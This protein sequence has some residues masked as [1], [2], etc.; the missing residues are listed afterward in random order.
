MR[1]R[2][3]FLTLLLALTAIVAFGRPDG[4]AS[5][6]LQDA[7]TP[8]AVATPTATVEV[9]TL[10][11]WYTPD[12]SGEFLAIGPIRVNDVLVA[13]PG[14]PNDRTM[15]GQVDFDDENN[16]DLPR[17]E[18]GETIFNAYL[19][20]PDDPDAL[21]SWIYPQD[22]PTLRPATL[23]IPIKAVRGPYDEYRGTATFVSRAL[24]AGGVL[25]IVLNPPED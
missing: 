22:D 13:G 1:V 18:F 5:A 21:F 19:V 25:I 2:I 14:Q 17:F 11:A 24:D 6:R 12:P 8:E 20:N 3:G 10:V 7:A 15:T 16:K 23:V 4:F 9:V